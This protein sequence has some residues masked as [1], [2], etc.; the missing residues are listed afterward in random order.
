[1]HGD[2]AV[3]Q[4]PRPTLWAAVQA[5]E[6][7]LDRAYRAARRSA[8]YPQDM[9]EAVTAKWLPRQARKGWTS[10]FNLLDNLLKAECP[11][12]AAQKEREQLER[13]RFCI[14]RPHDGTTQLF[15]E[16]DLLDA[17]HHSAS[18]DQMAHILAQIEGDEESLQV[19]RTPRGGLR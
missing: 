1:M 17:K 11:S 14:G 18:V 3:T 7:P 15:A 13:R 9:A 4:P 5:Y 10:A 2:D 8:D 19:R 12:E 16:L 6:L